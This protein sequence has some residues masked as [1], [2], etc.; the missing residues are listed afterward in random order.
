MIKEMELKTFP[1][2]ILKKLDF[3]TILEKLENLC[4]GS[5]GVENIQQQTFSNQ[6]EWIQKAVQQVVE[7]KEIILNDANFP[8]NGFDVLPFLGKISIQGAS[9]AEYEFVK[10]AKF[11]NTFHDILNFFSSKKRE[12]VYPALESLVKEI[13]WDKALMKEIDRVID[14][15]LEIVKETASPEL[16]MIRRKMLG[17][18]KRAI[19]C[20]C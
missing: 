9:L 20:F 19:I 13:Y 4:R 1:D 7:M 2:D 18:R 10:V 12:G 11:L 15:D 16:G 17:S 3:P 14:R 6:P 5:L 8:E